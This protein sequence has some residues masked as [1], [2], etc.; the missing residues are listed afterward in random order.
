[1]GAEDPTKISMNIVNRMW[2]IIY[3][4]EYMAYGIIVHGIYTCKD[5]AN[6]GFCNSPCLGLW[7]Q[8]C[9]IPMLI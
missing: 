3:G 6:H 7:K 2:Y 4:I 9:R 8:E 5:P 1:M